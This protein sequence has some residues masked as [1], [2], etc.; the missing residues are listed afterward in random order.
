MF[1]TQLRFVQIILTFS[2][3]AGLLLRN[4]PLL[5]AALVG[6]VLVWQ[7][8][9]L[10]G[11]L[12]IDTNEYLLT[13]IF[14]GLTFFPVVFTEVEILESVINLFYILLLVLSLVMV[15]FQDLSISKIGNTVFSTIFSFTI[16]SFIMSE[17]FFENLNHIIYLFLSLFFLKTIATFLNVQ[18]SNFQYFFNFFAVLVVM[19]GV[20]S[21]YDFQF[22]YI[23]LGSVSTALSVVFV[24]FLILKIRYEFEHISEL[25]NEIYLYDYLIAFLFSLYFVDS[26]NIINGLF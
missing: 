17:V 1:Q 24:N 18:F 7:L 6:L 3:F 20:T 23:I 11:Q 4:I 21:F 10:T 5:I 25:T 14:I 12:R 2:I 16:V 22:I 13:I 26:L 8:E 19:I 15:L 9:M